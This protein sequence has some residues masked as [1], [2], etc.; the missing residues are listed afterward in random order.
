MLSMRA[1][2][3]SELYTVRVCIS[4]SAES[5]IKWYVPRAL[6]QIL[7]SAEIR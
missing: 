5:Q 4:E 2:E 1:R 6:A 7:A 3:R